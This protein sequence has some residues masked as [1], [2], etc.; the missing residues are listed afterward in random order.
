MCRESTKG[1]K[2]SKEKKGVKACSEDLNELEKKRR[3]H[4]LSEG[5]KREEAHSLN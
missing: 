1:E 4:A 3:K 2:H 5:K